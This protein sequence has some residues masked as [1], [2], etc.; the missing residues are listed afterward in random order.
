MSPSREQ[1]CNS[2]DVISAHDAD[3]GVA[4][5]EVDDADPTEELTEVEGVDPHRGDEAE[6]VEEEEEELSK[7]LEE[8]EEECGGSGG[9]V[10][11]S[12]FVEEAVVGTVDIM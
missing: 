10:G 7:L 9:T 4:S 3:S 8:E 2:F 1:A 11:F 6:D 12:N 5:E